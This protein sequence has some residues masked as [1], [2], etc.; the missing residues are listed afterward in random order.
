MTPVPLRIL[1]LNWQDRENPQSGGAEVH[2]HETFGR[3][4][5]RGHSVTLLVSG[6]PGAT[7]RAELDGMEVHRTGGRYTF[8]IAA[9]LYY[10]RHLRHVPF[11]VVVEDLNKVPLFAPG[12]CEAP[13]VLLVHH[14]FG[15]TAFR[16]AS[17]PVAAATW[18]LERPIPR[19][20][21]GVPTIAVS[22]S[23][24]EDLAARGMDPDQIQVIPNGIDLDRFTP[25]PEQNRE[26]EPS[27]LYVGRLKRYKGVDLI[28]QAVARMNSDGV[29]CRLRI[30]GGGDYRQELEG[31]SRD[32]GVESQVEFLGFIPEEDKVRL[33]QRSWVHLLTS[34]KEG[35][36]ISNIEAAACGT[37][38][39]ASDAPGL[40]DSVQDGRTG[41]LVPHG[42][43]E[44]LTRRIVQL[45]HDEDLRR[46]MG[47]N[48]VEFAREFSWEA[49]AR[50]VEAVLESAR[51]I[52][53][54]RP[55]G[56]V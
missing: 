41:F 34:P 44:S 36:G 40:R 7:P 17:F 26:S 43:V 39:V 27:L 12:W 1:V 33:F 46:Q 14:L 22:D 25:G 47:R 18:L 56:A 55:E 38:T 35:W 21:Q 6:W 23:T 10:R 53:L 50:R 20:F 24:R 29:A 3:L 9:P 52:A 30:A 42:D 45:I 5:K 16:E 11:D 2:L 19:A 28:L 37:P 54:D 13:P 48:A 51:S 31:L 32:L 8:S 15:L 49:T 4:A